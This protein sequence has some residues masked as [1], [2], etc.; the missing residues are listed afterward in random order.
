MECRLVLVVQQHSLRYGM[1][2]YSTIR[3]GVFIPRSST[4]NSRLSAEAESYR[5]PWMVR[6]IAEDRPLDMSQPA[7]VDT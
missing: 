4:T 2:K 7:P 1:P 3:N 6:I 5:L